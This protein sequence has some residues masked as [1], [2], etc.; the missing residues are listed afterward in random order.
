MSLADDVMILYLL[1]IRRAVFD[2]LSIGVTDLER[3]ARFYDATLGALG[4]VRLWRTRRAA[5]YGHE[6][7]EGEAPFA[8]I[9]VGEQSA[10]IAGLHLAF[11]ALDREEV[12]AFHEAALKFG[13]VCDGP[14][15]IRENYDPGYYAAFARD[16]D[17]HRL[18]AVIHE[19]SVSA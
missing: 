16:P 13:G 5:G 11:S 10:S 19:T 2:H 15:G 6:G 1:K 18:E 12:K 9:D 7:F 4:Y 8:I 14:P 3:S 17:G